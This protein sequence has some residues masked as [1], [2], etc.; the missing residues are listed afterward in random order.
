MSRTL[1][2][3]SGPVLLFGGPY[4]NLS[5]ARAMRAVAEELKI[6][7]E[8]C[9]CTGDVVAYCGQPEA[10]VE[11]IR[12]WGIPVVMGNCEESLGNAAADCGCGFE[13]GSACSV[14]SVDW[15]NFAN[16]RI[17]DAQRAWMRGLPAQI[18]F[19]LAGRTFRVIHGGVRRINRFL[20]ASSDVTEKCEEL[21]RAGCDVVIGGHCGIPFGERVKA[22]VW[23]N[24][25][26]IGMPANDG[27]RDGWYLLLSPEGDEVCAE[28]RRLN[29]AVEAEVAAMRSVGLNG[30]YAE[31]LRSGLWPSM[32]VLPEAERGQRGVPLA[33]RAM[34]F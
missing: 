16:R 18:E 24:T 17:S 27:T 9:I 4:S 26:A 34:R 11:A 22:R 20:F 6:P 13:E 33:P 32:D 25:G 23:L 31:A 12:E 1:V 2:L 10:T 29:Y 19:E 7:A 3:A 14:L 21:D 28:W 30:G 5:A 15:Y 8:N